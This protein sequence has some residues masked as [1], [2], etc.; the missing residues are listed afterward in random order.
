MVKQW[1]RKKLALLITIAVLALLGI[2]IGMTAGKSGV[3]SGTYMLERTEQFIAQLQLNTVVP[4]NAKQRVIDGSPWLQ[5]AASGPLELW[6]EPAGG[7][8]AVANPGRGQWWSSLPGEADLQA[9]AG[10]GLL[11]SNPRS[12]IVFD[13]LRKEEKASNLTSSNT[14]EQQVQIRWKTL[15]DGVGISYEMPALD[16][17]LYVECTLTADGLQVHVPE[18]G[19][20]EAG[21]ERLVRYQLYPYMGAAL[22]GQEGFLFVPDGPGALIHFNKPINKKWK[23]YEYPVYGYDLAIDDTVSRFPRTSIAFPVYGIS[24]G[25]EALLAIIEHGEFY[26]DIVASPAGLQTAFNWATAQFNVRRMYPQPKGLNSRTLVYEQGRFEYSVAIRYVLLPPGESGYVEMAK[27]YRGYLMAAKGLSKLEH[28]PAAPRLFLNVLL[29]AME[30]GPLGTKTVVATTLGQVEQMAAALQQAG[31]SELEIGLTGWN[32]GGVPGNMPSLLPIE[33]QIGGDAELRKL[34][35]ALQERGVRLR[36]DHQFGVA[37]DKIGSGFSTRYAI[38][39][40][41]GVAYKF[42]RKNTG[43]LYR[44]NPGMLA[45]TYMPKLI[46][47]LQQL[48][49]THVAPM[50]LGAS[51]ASDFNRDRYTSREMSAASSLSVLRQLREAFG[52]VYTSGANAYV[53]GHVDHLF[54]FPAE[55]NH[56]M[57]VDEQVPFYP[58]ALHGLLTYSTSSGNERAQPVE[59]YLRDLEYGAMPY[60]MVTQASPSVL[61]NT[62][63]NRLYSSQFHTNVERIAREY[64]GYAEVN[65]DVAG[66]FIEDHRRLADGVYETVYEGGRTIWV[67][68]NLVPYEAMGKRVEAQAYLVTVEGGEA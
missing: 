9:Q 11:A 16:M 19:I 42:N 5:M 1:F 18:L 10:N 43:M 62:Q 45:D 65:R 34:A 52:T 24:R 46:K 35:A 33:G 57:P 54:Q 14:V 60:Y 40:I 12:A 30:R 67:N 4:A 15:P 51:V 39:Q 21:E 49:I 17:A 23:P 6:F 47:Q 3:A 28:V 29:S 38:R 25:D 59:G 50:Q 7:H 22:N 2:Y 8:I 61:Q 55:Y 13:Y 32:N 37:R 44:I 26:A 68:Y 20:L 36:L 64:N 56:D 58:I 66:Q 31:V 41:S 48:P 53:L 63:E 27:A